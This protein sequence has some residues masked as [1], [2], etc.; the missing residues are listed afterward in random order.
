MVSTRSA[1]AAAMTPGRDR[2]SAKSS[3]SS[4]VSPPPT[5]PS[6]SQ[7]QSQTTA[8]AAKTARRSTAAAAATAAVSAPGWS[9]IPPASTLFWMAVSLPLVA[10]DTG[11][12][13]LRPASMPGGS[14]HWPLWTPYALYGE[15]DHMYGFKQ[16]NAGNGFTAA[17]GIL[18]LIET[19]MYLAYL[20]LWY[21]TARPGPTT[22]KGRRVLT[23]RPGALAVLLGFSA[24]VM[25]VS[26]TALYWLNEYYS[27]F[28]NIGH[29]N[30][31]DLVLLWII[32]NGAWLVFP[33]L[34]IYY[35]GS[36]IV[37][38]LTKASATGPTRGAKYE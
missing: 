23:G 28:D 37:S 11:Y 7:S 32:P 25:T 9:H 13:L 24:A 8:V 20:G 4:S 3:S 5:T 18:N 17:Q 6:P 30:L 22:A 29:N 35:M 19:L 2:A 21:F 33:T 16:W 31:T 34:M 1:S 36:E 27:G 10:W 38:G 14:L 12:V 26:K 15:V